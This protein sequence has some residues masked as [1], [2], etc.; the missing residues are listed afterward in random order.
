MSTKRRDSKN[1][2]LQ[3]GE[4][5]R[6]DGRYMYKYIDCA[7]KT[8]YLYSWRL[9]RTDPIP[10]GCKDTVPLRE[11][12]K[13]AQRDKEDGIVSSGYDITVLQLVEKYV[14][15]KVGVTQNTKRVYSF[16]LG[17]LS[18][19]PFGDRRIDRVKHSDAKG[20][21][22]KLQ[23]DGKGYSS[24]NLV[25]NVVK[26]AFAMAVD[27]DLLRKN[28][29]SF[30]LMSVIVNDSTSREA[31]SK[32]QEEQ[33]LS[34]LR[35]DSC[36]SKYYDAVYILFHTGLRISEFSGL[37]ISDLD[38]NEG[39]IKVDHQLQRSIGGKYSISGTKTDCGTRLIPM[40]DEV[41][42][43]FRR[44]LETRSKP[45][46]EPIVDGKVGFLFLD[47]NGMP[48]TA[49]NWNCRFHDMCRRY[50]KL[51]EIPMPVIT[52]HICRHT[53]CS[54]M[55]K[56]GMNPKTLQ[57]IMGHSNIGITLNVYTHIGFEDVKEEML[58]VCNGL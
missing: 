43:C 56:A 2:I 50:N 16:V 53:F 19:D 12:I 13:I 55:A 31:I 21:L 42:K 10:K 8:K 40:T 26:P 36:F 5:Q 25:R 9:V 14:A 52:P 6:K 46:K 45:E 24:I 22:I 3:N 49:G 47:R 27:D 34:F 41:K 39:I 20:W 58:S 30:P 44:I 48:V 4:S 37:T 29:F 1:R 57:K 7:G 33:F 18:K 54:N 35:E 28:P 15:Q 17:I 38:I 11:K 23:K 32:Q 51:H